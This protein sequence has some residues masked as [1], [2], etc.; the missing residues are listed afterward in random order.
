MD[1]KT[2][3][4]LFRMDMSYRRHAQGHFFEAMKQGYAAAPLKGAMEGMP[5]SKT[6]EYTFEDW[7]VLDVYQTSPI[8]DRSGGTTTLFFENV[9]IWM[10]QYLG[11][12]DKKTIPC[13][14]AALLQNY[15]KEVYEG[16]RGPEVYHHEDGLVYYNQVDQNDFFG[17]TWGTESI[18]S[19]TGILGSHRYQASWLADA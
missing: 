15:E 2:I 3:A 11:K 4:H 17:R 8:S 1:Q 19:P 7:R 14:K 5:H 10:M 6:I 18:F 13:L 16:G 9:P 12:Y